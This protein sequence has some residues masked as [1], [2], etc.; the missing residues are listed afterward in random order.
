MPH[1]SVVAAS[2]GLALALR[3][4]PLA[5]QATDP[6]PVSPRAFASLGW[7]EGVWRGAGGGVDA[8]FEDFRWVD[9]STVLRHSY[10]DSTLAEVTETGEIRLRGGLAH[11]WREGRQRAGVV[12]LRNDSLQFSS[13]VLWI[14]RSNDHWTAIIDQGRTVYQLRRH[15]R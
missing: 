5:A 9:D 8:F 12:L 7:L 3:G 4:L 11:Q 2:L 14:R 10:A 13:G 1:A 6:I 15:R